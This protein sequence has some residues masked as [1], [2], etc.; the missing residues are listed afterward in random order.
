[1]ANS[2]TAAVIQHAI[3]YPSGHLD[4][5]AQ[6]G[7]AFEMSEDQPTPQPATIADIPSDSGDSGQPTAPASASFDA[8]RFMLGGKATLTLQGLR[9][10]YTY[11]VT[12]SDPDQ[13]G[14]SVLFVALLTGP[15][16]QSDYTY[17]G[18]LEE[19]TGQIRL[20]RKSRYTDQSQPVVALR[21]ACKRIWAGRSIAPASIYHI[22]ACGRCGRAL[23]VPSSIA[24][25]FGPE[26]LGKLNGGE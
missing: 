20:T 16:N 4:R 19:L 15:D 23:T 1:M 25:G 11:R 26:C 14:R 2:R 17:M 9:D 10:R 7:P 5:F 8:K 13:A 18:L 21:W 22:G 3:Q 24:S 12:R 6:F